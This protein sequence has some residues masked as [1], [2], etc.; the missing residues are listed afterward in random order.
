MTDRSD[1]DAIKH[2]IS[3]SDGVSFSDYVTVGDTTAVYEVPTDCDIV[4]PMSAHAVMDDSDDE[5]QTCSCELE[6]EWL[7]V[8][9]QKDMGAFKIIT[10]AQ[11][12]YEKVDTN[13]F[14]VEKHLQ[15]QLSGST[16]KET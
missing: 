7:V 15:R 11:G 1:W 12:L 10:D 4:T 14:C 6:S 3:I 13:V 9:A 16:K 5:T 8:T 2:C